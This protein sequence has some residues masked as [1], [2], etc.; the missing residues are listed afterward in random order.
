MNQ[1]D[2]DQKCQD[3]LLELYKQTKGDPAVQMSMY[4]IGAALGMERDAASRVAEELL[5][6]Q[7]AEIRTLSGGIGISQDGIAEAQKLSGSLTAA[8]EIGFKLGKATVIDEDG[9]RA[10]EEITLD[11]KQRTGSLAL[12]FDILNEFIA[13]LKTIDAQLSSPNPKAAILRQCFQS[14]KE[15]AEKAGALESAAKIKMLIDD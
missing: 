5:G 14:L 3:F 10:I 4:D 1:V 13:D 15:T 7:L 9:R 11:L 2:I 12:E 8:E 6:W